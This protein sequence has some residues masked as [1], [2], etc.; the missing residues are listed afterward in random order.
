MLDRCLLPLASVTV[1]RCG[2]PALSGG[3]LPAASVVYRQCIFAS[4]SSSSVS[5]TRRPAAA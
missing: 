1:V 4:T 2:R 5:G 3:V